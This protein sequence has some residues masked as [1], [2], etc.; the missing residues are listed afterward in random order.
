MASELTVAQLERMLNT[1]RSMLDSLQK[2]RSKLEK[3]LEVIDRRI[4][5]IGGSAR[6]SE[7]R[8]TKGKLNAKVKARVKGRKRPKNEKTLQQVVIDVLQQNKKGLVLADL[9]KEVLATGYKSGSAH[10]P[11]TVYQCLYNNSDN[12]VQDP[13]TKAYRLK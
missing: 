7:E 12:F 9:A 2:K 8:S 3:Q 13:G 11:N 6:D 1:K 4:S 10:F 5:A